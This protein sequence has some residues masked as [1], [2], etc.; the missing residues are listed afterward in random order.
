MILEAFKQ[1]EFGKCSTGDYVVLSDQG[2]YVED[3]GLTVL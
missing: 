1:D 3:A 2:T